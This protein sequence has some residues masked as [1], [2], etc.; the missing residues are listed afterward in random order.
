MTF[1]SEF[2][3]DNFLFSRYPEFFKTPGFYVDIG[4]GHPVMNSNSHWLRELGWRG[5]NIDGNGYWL[6]DWPTGQMFQAV[7]ST[8]RQVHFESH[9]CK[10]LSR[11][12]DIEPNTKA[13]TLE[14]I[15]EANSVDKIGLL[16]VDAEGHEYEVIQSMDLEKHRPQFIISE[17]STYG[18]GEDFRVMD[19]LV[20]NGYQVIH[21]TTANLI[22]HHD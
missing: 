21:R 6:P 11:V 7:I 10:E 17:Y 16:S 2:G 20:K 22:Y 4:C 18:I 5:L 9:P 3:E 12:A 1:H 15:L 8:R 14:S 19:Y 13:V